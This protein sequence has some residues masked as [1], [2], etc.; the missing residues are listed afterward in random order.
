MTGAA[1]GGAGY[2]QGKEHGITTRR[3]AARVRDD[4]C[5]LWAILPAYHGTLQLI[6]RTCSSARVYEFWYM[7]GVMDRLREFSSRVAGGDASVAFAA[8]V[9]VHAGCGR[10]VMESRLSEDTV[11]CQCLRCDE[12]GIFGP[13]D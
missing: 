9:L 1:G 10:E 6:L 4:P 13:A 11:A 7:D 12:T 5:T 3:F 2:P 8:F